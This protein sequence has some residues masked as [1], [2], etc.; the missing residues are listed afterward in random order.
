[1]LKPTAPP[2]QARAT[3][4]QNS[5]YGAKKR[6]FT[7][8]EVINITN[9]F[10]RVL[11]RGGFGTVYHGFIG[12]VQ[13]AVK[14]LSHSTSHGYRQFQEEVHQIFTLEYESLAQ[15]YVYCVIIYRLELQVK[16]LM[17]VH[18]RNLTSLVGYCIEGTNMALIY[19][20]MK[21][22]DF[23]SHLIGSLRFFQVKN[24]FFLIFFS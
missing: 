22:G 2:A 12:D 24:L 8:S 10:E 14:K 15:N 6:Q 17:T 7:Y 1:M 19:E 13:V 4:I 3:T 5:I 21:N 9:N 18:H 20:Y 16:L 23:D 11:G